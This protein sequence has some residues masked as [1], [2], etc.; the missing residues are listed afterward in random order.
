[1][2]NE[3]IFIENPLNSPYKEYLNLWVDAFW[4]MFENLTRGF[5]DV[6]AV[7]GITFHV[8]EG[9]IFGF[10]DQNGAGK[11]TNCKDA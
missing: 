9:E 1:M 7:D 4:L 11:T 8:N 6:T 5:G 10:L 3:Y 2:S